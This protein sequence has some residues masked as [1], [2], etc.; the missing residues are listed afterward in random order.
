[1]TMCKD[2]KLSGIR[3]IDGDRINELVGEIT[4]TVRHVRSTL[5]TVVERGIVVTVYGVPIEIQLGA[6]FATGSGKHYG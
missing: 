4:E 6:D 1:M 5:T 3:D 2:E